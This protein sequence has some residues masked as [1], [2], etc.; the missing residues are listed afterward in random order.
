MNEGLHLNKDGKLELE[1][2]LCD[3]EIKRREGPTENYIRGCGFIIL[4]KPS[5]RRLQ[6]C[7]GCDE[8]H[9]FQQQLVTAYIEVGAA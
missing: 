6:R 3:P 8:I 4:M 2:W 5:D 9:S 7:P 1:V